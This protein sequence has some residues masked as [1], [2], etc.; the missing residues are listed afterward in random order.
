MSPLGTGTNRSSPL[1]K[2]PPDL[3]A[4]DQHPPLVENAI[5]QEGRSRLHLRQASHIDPAASLVF[6]L[7]GEPY[8]CHGLVVVE[9]HEDIKV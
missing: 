9:H 6:Q 3:G 8:S 4:V 7:A 5:Q 1:L 2:G